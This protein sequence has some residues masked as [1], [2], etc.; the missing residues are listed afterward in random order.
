MKRAWVAVAALSYLPA[1]CGDAPAPAASFDSEGWIDTSPAG[2]PGPRP[3]AGDGDGDDDDDDDDD[4]DE[5]DGGV[6]AFWGLFGR[7]DAGALSELEGEFFAE[8]GEREL[9]LLFFAA[10]V[11]GTADGCTECTA[12]WDIE[13]GAPEAEIDMDGACAA[14]GP[15]QIEG[16][17]LRMGITDGGVLLQDD[18]EGWQSI[19]EVVF[20]EGE[21]VLEW[22]A[23]VGG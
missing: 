18:G 14:H 11:R 6:E 9:C 17:V 7:Y 22:E 16:V 21:I 13:L 5:G 1:A 12:A 4:D 2:P 20:E 10:T 19:G 23:E 3:G 8:D 15:A